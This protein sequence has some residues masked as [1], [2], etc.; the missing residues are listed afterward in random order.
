MTTTAITPV[1]AIGNALHKMNLPLPRSIPSDRFIQTIQTAIINNPALIAEDVNRQSLYTACSKAATDG[2]ILDGREAALVPYYNKDTKQKE[3]GYLPM[4]AGVIKRMR[5]SGEL[6]TVSAHVVYDKDH[7]VHTLG[8]KEDI[9]HVPPPLNEDRGKPIAVY[10]IGHLKDGTY[11]IC[12][13]P[14]K[15]IMEIKACSKM[16]GIW[17]GPFWNQQWEKSAIRRLGKR[18]PS[19]AEQDK[20]F[21]HDN[22]HYDLPGEP[23]RVEGEVIEGTDNTKAARVIKG[24]QEPDLEAEVEEPPPDLI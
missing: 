12:V 1:T 15:D 10:A 7:F 16:K 14:K 23:R 8:L 21:Q 22:E 24:E 19:S 6:A 5:N 20:V 11:Q 18:M 2:L 3:V 4:V 17:E 9:E 13:I